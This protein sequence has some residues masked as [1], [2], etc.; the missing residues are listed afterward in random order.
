[1]LKRLLIVVAVLLGL[2]VVADRYLA[3]AAG[4]AA[5]GQVRRSAHTPQKP[6]VTFSGFPFVTQAVSGRFRRVDVVAK[7][8]PASGLTF[9]RIDARFS[10]VKIK[11]GK[12]LSGELD[13]V[14][15]ERAAATARLSYGDLNTY[16]RR[17]G[18]LTVSVEG[19]ALSVAGQVRVKGALISGKGKAAITLRPGS[20]V[21]QA[22][23]ATA[24]GVVLPAGAVRL[25]SV[26]VPTD[27]LPFG[28]V[29]QSVDIEA[30]A[31]VLRGTA[32]GIVIPT[33]NLTG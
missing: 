26:T 25:L 7:N 29:L 17:R 4:D 21:L 31:L 16:L 3:S 32:A 24:N 9:T 5:G 27:G 19:G 30:D 15:T 14:A 6:D 18:S 2:A 10:G 33:R 20:I 23:S 22:T 8:V 28:M 13:A 1:M 12:A 11:F